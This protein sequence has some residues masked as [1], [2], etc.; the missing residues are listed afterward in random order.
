MFDKTAIPL[1]YSPD[2]GI[3]R[4]L[5]KGEPYLDTN[6]AAIGG[7]VSKPRS[8]LGSVAISVETNPAIC[9]GLSQIQEP[10]HSK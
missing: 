6:A 9:K 7:L 8:G 1:G 3:E 5:R 4:I 2:A 10:A